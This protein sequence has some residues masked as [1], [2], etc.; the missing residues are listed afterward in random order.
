MTLGEN[1]T[2]LRTTHKLSQ[3][4]L[5]EQL[6]VSRQ[7]VSKWET[8][9]SIPE[10]DK[11]IMMS[12]LFHI[13]L[14][15]LVRADAVPNEPPCDDEQSKVTYIV[16]PKAR[17]SKQI[18]GYILLTVGLLSLVLGCILSEVL[19]IAGAFMILYGV[20]CVVTKKYTGIWCGWVSVLL[21]CLPSVM[22]G[23]RF[24]IAG[25]TVA[26]SVQSILFWLLLI[27]MSVVTI[28]AIL[29]NRKT[30]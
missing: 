18:I 8:D 30:K 1:I 10:L 5:A 25:G 12:D 11:L 20:I 3:S 15:E 22:I 2:A 24:S 13:T 28:R 27:I 23:V 9:A 21:L 19:L 16:Q 7:S 29:R 6:N 26:I 17:S 4:E 14:D